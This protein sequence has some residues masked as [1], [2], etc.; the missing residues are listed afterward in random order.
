MSIRPIKKENYVEQVYQQMLQLLRSG[1]WKPG[2]RIPSEASLAEQFN[3]SRVTI[4]Q[5]LQKLKALDLIESISGS[6]SFVRQINGTEATAAELM[7]AI[8]VSSLTNHQL[9]QFREML[10]TGTLHL[11]LSASQPVDLSGLEDALN[12]MERCAAAG[13]GEGFNREDMRFHLQIGEMTSNPLIVRTYQILQDALQLTMPA[14]LDRFGYI[15]LSYHQKILEGMRDGDA[16][17]AIRMLSEH[18]RLTYDEWDISNDGPI[19]VQPIK[20]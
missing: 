4:R 19:S 11:V 3:V 12:C 15:G 9:S 7:Q 20:T 18:I 6:G 8:Y 2:C 10:E 17:K 14:N 1:D 5:A 13:D 16:E